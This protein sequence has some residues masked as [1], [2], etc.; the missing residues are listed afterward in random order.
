VSLSLVIAREAEHV[1]LYSA[2]SLFARLYAFLSL[3]I[4]TD[5]RLFFPAAGAL[6]RALL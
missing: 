3:D 1:G 6:C 2:R 4:L 5:A